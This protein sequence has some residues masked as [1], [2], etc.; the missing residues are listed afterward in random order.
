M[1]RQFITRQ[2]RHFSPA[3]SLAALGIK[4]H[5]KRL[6]DPIR[7]LVRIAQKTVKDQPFDKL[8]D[9]LVTLLS[10]ACG[11]VEVNTR[12]R[13]DPVVQ[14]AWGRERCAEQSV[15][16][17]TLDACTEEN[18][19]QMQEA[20]DEIFQ[21]HSRSYRHP[22]EKEWLI[23]DVDLTGMPCGKKAELATKGYF[24]TKRNRRGRQMGRVLASQ[25]QEVVV[26]QLYSG[27]AHLSTS[28]R[29]LVE[30]A[31]KT[32]ALTP[33][34][35]RHTLIRM[36]AGGGTLDEINWLLSRG[37]G[38]HGKEFSWKRAEKLAKTVEQWIDDPVIPGRQVGWVTIEPEEY[39]R[40]VRRIAGR[41]RKKNG[42]WGYAVIIST[43]EPASVLRLTETAPDADDTALLL[44]Y[45]R[46]YDQ[47]G[48]GVETSFLEDKQGLG[49]TKRNKKR[50]AAQQMLMLL[51]TL[52][53]NLL[54]WA[55]GWLAKDPDS[56][57]RKVGIKRL[58]RDVLHTSGSV[59]FN[60]HH[61]ICEVNLNPAAPWSKALLD[62]LR[63]LLAS[64]HVAV[65]LDKT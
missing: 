1:P 63:S 27:T 48:G 14:R 30:A 58:V 35:R 3:V 2:P 18:V 24:T 22:Y 39:V 6:L 16:Q 61:H 31:E 21:R 10:G 9:V 52:A 34:K 44:A 4:V 19:E 41:L 11:V 54:I 57:L 60:E 29:E 7:K 17:Q 26:D 65:N 36:D 38:Y 47:R 53:H 51:G 59:C 8:V 50:F 20:L 15:A 28:L 64:Q 37:Y 62:P 45:V 42:Q 56:P 13:P 43:V 32:L 49:I 46:F 25:Y 40:P 55:R 12:L 23:L 5:R 33:E